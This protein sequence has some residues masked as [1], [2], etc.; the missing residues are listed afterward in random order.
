MTVPN[1][2]VLKARPI[3]VQR[4]TTHLHIRAAAHNTHYRVAVNVQSAEPPSEVRYCV[5][6]PFHGAQVQAL[7]A[8]PM[9]FTSVVTKPG[10]LAMDFVR[11]PPFDPKTLR[12]L[13][14]DVPGPGNDLEDL[15]GGLVCEAI[16]DQHA[17]VYAIGSRWGPEPRTPDRVFGFTPGNGV[18]DIHMNQGNNARFGADDGVWQDG[19]L[20]VQYAAPAEWAAIFL[21]FQS[22]SWRTDNLSG[23]AAHG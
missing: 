3:R 16:R 14:S 11:Q 1:Y 21:A 17:L 13:P 5:C 20:L 9:G 22:Q 2:G 12:L 10:G 7:A 8:L 19:A 18:H 23:H 4:G 15:V 6:R